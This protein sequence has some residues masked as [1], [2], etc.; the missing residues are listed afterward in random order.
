MIQIREDDKPDI[1]FWLR[2]AAQ[3]SPIETV[4]VLKDIKP[5]KKIYWGL[6]CNLA[7]NRGTYVDDIILDE[8]CEKIIQ[9]HEPFYKFSK[10]SESIVRRLGTEGRLVS[11]GVASLININFAYSFAKTVTVALD[12]MIDAGA[13][14]RG[15]YWVY[16]VESFIDMNPNLADE[17]ECIQAIGLIYD[18]KY[19]TYNMDVIKEIYLESRKGFDTFETAENT[20]KEQIDKVGI[21]IVN[22]STEIITSP[23]FKNIERKVSDFVGDAKDAVIDF[24]NDAAEAYVDFVDDKID[25]IKKWWK[26]L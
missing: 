22:K 13:F 5:L 20:V 16:E 11:M 6:F 19:S 4:V 3:I 18:S 12:R 26:N 21:K 24:A 25:K 10:I 2:E 1:A 23:E 17:V 7:A 15:G 9:I 14:D 8:I